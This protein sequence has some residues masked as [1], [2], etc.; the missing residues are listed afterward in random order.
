MND[1]EIERILAEILSLD[2]DA[3]ALDDDTA[4]MG[5]LPEFDSM[6][7][8]SILTA[9]EDQYGIVIDDDEVDADIFE[10]VGSLKRFVDAKVTE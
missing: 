6:A 7:V 4:L 1:G 2:V 8:V 10:T 3:T 9:I 5:A